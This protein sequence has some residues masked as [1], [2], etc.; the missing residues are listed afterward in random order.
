LVGYSVLKTRS[1]NHPK[2]ANTTRLNRIR[3]KTPNRSGIVCLPSLGSRTSTLCPIVH[4]LSVLPFS[5]S[6]EACSGVISPFG[7]LQFRPCKGRLDPETQAAFFRPP[8]I[9]P[10]FGGLFRGNAQLRHAETL[11]APSP[12][13]C[14]LLNRSRNLLGMPRPTPPTCAIPTADRPSRRE[15]HEP[16]A[17]SRSRW[18]YRMSGRPIAAVLGP[19]DSAASAPPLRTPS[20]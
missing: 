13:V 17:G 7:W 16:G 14:P 5:T 6:A 4:S 12:G 20:D 11:R 10:T 8:Q 9:R 1:T 18:P 2:P 19:P 15:G 3:A